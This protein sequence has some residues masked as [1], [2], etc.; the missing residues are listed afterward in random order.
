MTANEVGTGRK[1]PILNFQFPMDCQFPISNGAAM[2][3]KSHIAPALLIESPKG[4][5]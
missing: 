2:I 3:R 1:L 5:A 4:G